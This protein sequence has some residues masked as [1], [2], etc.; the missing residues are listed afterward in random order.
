[1]LHVLVYNV[2]GLYDKTPLFVFFFFNPCSGVELTINAKLNQDCFL[3]LTFPV[4]NT[5]K[6]ICNCVFFTQK[7]EIWK[8][9]TTD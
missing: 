6:P 9:D 5:R 3:N 8:H 7:A 2:I 4:S 1:M